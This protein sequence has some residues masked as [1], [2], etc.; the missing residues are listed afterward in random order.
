MNNCDHDIWLRR[1]N[2]N[3]QLIEWYECKKCLTK[4]ELKELHNTNNQVR[5]IKQ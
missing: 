2:P 1:L 3:G 4:F 5:E